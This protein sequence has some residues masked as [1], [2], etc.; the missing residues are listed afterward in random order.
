MVK[1]ALLA[2]LHLPFLESATQ[3]K[4][5]DFAMKSINS[6]HPDAVVCL[7]DVTA[8]GELNAADVFSSAVGSLEI[9]QLVLLG[10]SDIR[11]KETIDKIQCLET[12]KELVIGDI[13]LIGLNTADSSLS[14]ED[15]KLLATAD[16]N[17]IVCMHHPPDRVRC[18]YR[19]NVTEYLQDRNIRACVYAHVHYSKQ[20]GNLYSIQ[21]LDPDKAKGTPPCVTYMLV[22]D[23][24][25]QLEYDYFPCEKPVDLDE[26]IGISCF[27]L[28]CDVEFAIEHNVRNIELR[29]SATEFDWDKLK[30]KVQRWKNNGGKYLSLHMPNFRYQ[31]YLT[32]IEDWE[33]AVLLA[34]ELQVNGVTV[35]VPRVSVG[36]MHG[37]VKEELLQFVVG[38]IKKLSEH[39]VVGIENLHMGSQD[40]D[41][42]N[43]GFG[44][45]PEECL[46]FVKD[47]NQRF[48]Y[49]RVGILLD[50]GHARN[51]EPFS[52]KYTIST[53]Y[54]MEG[55]QIV[56]Y[57]V[58]QVIAVGDEMENHTA[59][60]DV[61]GP[62][63]SYCSFADC[64]NNG[65][66]NKKPVFLEI[67]GGTEAYLQSI[68]TMKSWEVHDGK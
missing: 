40:K 37:D 48:G 42:A 65:K 43:R 7:G 46:E 24:E 23:D 21:A 26:Y 3:Y 13:R 6:N 29:P 41:D 36:K 20:D 2:D 35:H 57:H 11:A 10:N 27:D 47:I 53:W 30:E 32:G 17:T 52:Q 9:P 39:C 19:K 55:Q 60:T 64:W 33:K 38:Q 4:V 44:F 15:E 1:L 68:Q 14:V 56:A 49:E 25:I 66:I 18:S 8:C 34:N 63:I 28:N 61:Y 5:L 22:D 16:G 12:V 62:T 58:H 31:N 51:N 54:G 67:R 59:V 45:I 50:V